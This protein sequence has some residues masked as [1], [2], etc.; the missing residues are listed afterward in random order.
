MGRNRRRSV[1]L[2]IVGVMLAGTA[3]GR[4]QQVDQVSSPYQGEYEYQVGS[5]LEPGVSVDGVLIERL[6]VAPRNPAA[7]PEENTV[8]V[9]IAYSL[10]NGSQR[11]ARVLLVLLLEDE[12]GNV[13]DRLELPPVR[14]GS[15]KTKEDG[16]RRDVRG[17]A[18]SETRKLYLY[19]ELQ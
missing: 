5:D 15:G 9:E 3:V 14:I 13:L 1:F 12:Q 11:T 2:G 6:R 7:S 4:A 10:T 8:E 16:E 19:C 17:R 18:I